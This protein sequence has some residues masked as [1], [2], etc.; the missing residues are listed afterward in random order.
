MRFE[1]KMKI[2]LAFDL[3]LFARGGIAIYIGFLSSVKLG[4]FSRGYFCGLGF[5]LNDQRVLQ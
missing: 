3:L 5:S 2:R 1:S 4:D